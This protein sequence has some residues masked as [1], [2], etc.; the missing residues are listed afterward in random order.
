MDLQK[1]KNFIVEYKILR[2]TLLI[3]DRQRKEEGDVL[4]LCKNFLSPLNLEVSCENELI[5][6][7]T[8]TYTGSY[9]F[10]ELYKAPHNSAE[11]NSTPYRTI[12]NHVDGSPSIILEDFIAMPIRMIAQVITRLSGSLTFQIKTS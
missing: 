12:S 1:T 10:V 9:M 11:S 6:L 2:Y 7:D 3:K 8:K 5:E 4:I